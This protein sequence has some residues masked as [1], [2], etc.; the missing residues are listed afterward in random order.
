VVYVSKG[1][2]YAIKNQLTKKEKD[3]INFYELQWHLRHNVPTIEE[4]A[5][6]L[7]LSQVTVN[8]YLQRQPVVKALETRGI[9]FRQHTQDELTATQ[10]AAAVTMSNFADTRDNAVKLDQLGI[11]PATYYAWLNDPQFQNL[12]ENLANQNLKNIKPTAIGE[13]TKKINAGDWNAV[14][15][16]LDVTGTLQ[17]NDAPQSEQLIKAF[18]EIIQRHVKDP[19]TI[20]AIAQDLKLAS[21]NR[22][23][24]V[25]AQPQRQITGELVD[26]PELEAA[27]RKLG[28]I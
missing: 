8:Y 7:S 15:F 25:V 3:L 27:K 26:D 12:V 19:E 1:Q 9:P 2:Y 22:T 10:V 4:V 16:Y 23:L 14:K 13:L 5:K 18:V 24:E 6:Y 11:N 21:A 20:V 17:N 28:V